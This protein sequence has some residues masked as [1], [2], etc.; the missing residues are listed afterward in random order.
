MSSAL[1]QDVKRGLAWS[2]LGKLVTQLFTWLSTFFVI[3]FLTP[4]DYGIIE[5]CIAIISFS[6]VLSEG[7]LAD[8]IVR[9]K[10]LTPKFLKEVFTV[11][12]LLNVFFYLIIWV[13][14][15]LVAS[16]F[17]VDNLTTVLRVVA[18]QL[19]ISSFFIVPLGKLRLDMDFK[20]IAVIDGIV[21]VTNAIITFLC[22][23]NGMGY[24]ALV[25]GTL[26]ANIVKAIMLNIKTKI[27]YGLTT[28]LEEIKNVSSFSIYTVISRVL[29][30]IFN[31]LDVII[32]GRVLG[33]VAL[34]VYSVALQIAALPLIKVASIIN[35][36]SFSAYAKVSNE[37]DKVRYYFL[38]TSKLLALVSFPVFFGIAALAPL[39]VPLFFGEKWLDSIVPMQI[40]AFIVPFR[41]QVLS[42]Q[43]M[44]QGI[45]KPKINSKNLVVGI[46][47]ISL[48]L[49]IGS[50]AGIVG[51]AIGWVSA[52]FIY[53]FVVVFNVAKQL[54]IDIN[55]YI[56]NVVIPLIFASIMWLAVSFF[57]TLDI[58]IN[59]FVEILVKVFIG[60]SLY[61]TLLLMFGKKRYILPLLSFLKK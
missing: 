26:G 11:S 12:I 49:L 50:N 8:S 38:L 51:T 2:S 60:A 46:F 54:K 9:Y 45:G 57:P 41:V 56:I 7:G 59:S 53:F 35:Q 34:G 14:S 52:F 47:L 16:F 40:F 48:G 13:T 10:E 31:K 5:I 29:W 21:G 15:P 37:V 22:A 58:F 32:V 39:F 33:V 28:R 18:L 55:H 6:F 27:P 24:W 17:N 43:A 61:I 30:V 3:R 25:Y 1:K 19:P 20:S 36:I 42:C 23:Y 4:N 44:F